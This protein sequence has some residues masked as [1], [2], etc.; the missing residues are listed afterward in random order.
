MRILLTRTGDPWMDWGLVAFYHMARQHY[1]YMAACRLTAGWLDVE[2]KPQ[3]KTEEYGEIIFHYLRERLNDLILP[4]VEM[5]VLGMDYRRPGSGGFNDPAYTISLTGQEKQRLKEARLNAGAQVSVSLRRN[6]VGLKNDWLK[7]KDELKTAVSNF[8]AQQGQA[9]S[10]G[11]QCQL[12]GRNAPAKAYSDMRQNK[13]P[14][15]NQHHNNRVRGYLSTV[16]TGT[17]CPT[18]NMLNIFAATHHNIP[19]F[20]EGQKMTHLLL[21]V[22][23]DLAVLYKI[24]VNTSTRLLDLLDPQLTTYRTNIRDLRQPSLYQALIGVYFSIAHR[25]EPAEEEYREDPALAPGER[26]ALHRWV[27]LRFSKGQNVS[28]A[29]FNLLE[30]HHRL[31]DLVRGLDYGSAGD[32]RGNLYTTFF[33]A[34]TAGDHRLADEVARGIIFRDW[35]RVGRGLFA[36]LKE[37]R[38]PGGRVRWNGRAWPFFEAFVDYAAGEVDHLLEPEL[39]EDLKVVGRTIGINFREDIALLTRLNNAPDAGVLRGV[40]SEAFF[41]MYKRKAGSKKEGGAD[42]LVPGEARVENILNNVTAD[43]IEAVRDILLIYACLSALRTQPA[44][45]AENAS[46]AE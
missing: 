42:L 33:G 38:A 27:V 23:D 37:S 46:K 9:A 20:V 7:L 10:S 21:P 5:K 43:N 19:Y 26:P 40:L 1:R 14:F 44:E 36:L 31:F 4:A 18:C 11:D 34:I 41:K 32:R 16:T 2:L 29:H 17:M 28:F 15:Y 39:M 30:V 13:N 35:S 8:L 3:I 6:Y 24:F 25:Y 45:K 12:C 22:V